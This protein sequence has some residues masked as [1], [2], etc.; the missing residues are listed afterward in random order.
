MKTS[1]RNFLSAAALAAPAALV[2]SKVS[3]DAVPVSGKPLKMCVFADLHY[4]PGGFVNDTPEFLE[5]IMARAEAAGC[6]MMIHLGDFIHNV[7]QPKQKAFLK[8]YND[9]KIPAITSS[10]ITIRTATTT[11][12]PA[13]PIVCPMATIPST[14]AVSAS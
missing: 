1:R 10:A 5:K 4:N 12:R 8:L 9:F 2:A 14:R 3:A 13:T 11:R 6:D 7:V